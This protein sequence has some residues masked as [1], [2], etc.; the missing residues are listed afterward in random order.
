M[1]EN[2]SLFW[3]INVRTCTKVARAQIRTRKYAHPAH[4][5]H[6]SLSLLPKNEDQQKE[7]HERFIT[8]RS[9]KW[10]RSDHISLFTRTYTY[11]QILVSALTTPWESCPQ[12]RNKIPSSKA[13]DIEAQTLVHADNKRTCA[14][15]AIIS[16]LLRITFDPPTQNLTFGN[17]SVAIFPC[18][19]QLPPPLSCRLETAWTFLPQLA[20]DPALA[21][22]WPC[23]P[24]CHRLLYRTLGHVSGQY[25]RYPCTASDNSGNHTT[26]TWALSNLQSLPRIHGGH[27]ILEFSS[28]EGTIEIQVLMQV[29]MYSLHCTSKSQTLEK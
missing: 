21:S 24:S 4:W 14:Q 19:A 29:Q 25:R 2:A 6:S 3:H 26:S 16:A 17:P 20:F 1:Q 27:Y 28:C 13:L 12:P 22:S 23:P 8:R 9:H 10:L 18:G 7:K 11:I 15:S 5:L